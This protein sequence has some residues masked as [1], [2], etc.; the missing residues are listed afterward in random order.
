MNN[1]FNTADIAT[2]YPIVGTDTE[3][4]WLHEENQNNETLLITVGDSWTWGD[5][6]GKINWIDIY[7]D[8][9]R[10]HTVYGKKLSEKLK[11]DW[12]LLARPGCSNY[13]ML[14]KLKLF[15]NQIKL[16]KSKYRRIIITVVLTEDFREFNYH[17]ELVYFLPYYSL[18]ADTKDLFNFL[19]RAENLLIKNF[20]EVL[21]DI[22]VE[23]YITRAFTDFWPENKNLYKE[24]LDQTWCDVFQDEVKFD[25]YHKVVPFIGQM[26]IGGITKLIDS[27]TYQKNIMKNNF[28]EIEEKITARYN[29]FDA[30]WYNIKGSSWHPN[31]MGHQRFAEYLFEKIKL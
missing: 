20:Q 10:L 16:L 25:R 21:N 22:E 30:S 3:L 2:G 9:V 23:H 31:D 28:I 7:D 14:D 1:I 12:I 13:W 26:A 6:L 5:H 19:S 24:I 15:A 17:E 27:C 4:Y 11:A 8:P 29:F 18:I